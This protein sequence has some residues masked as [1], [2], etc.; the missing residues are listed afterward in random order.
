[1]KHLTSRNHRTSSSGKVCGTKFSRGVRV[2]VHYGFHLKIF[3]TSDQRAAARYEVKR[4][5]PRPSKS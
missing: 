1:M 4:I 2:S 5:S 3:I